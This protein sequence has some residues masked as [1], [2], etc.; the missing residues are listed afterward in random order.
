MTC[1]AAG[2]LRIAG[3]ATTTARC[4]AHHC[5][6]RTGIRASHRVPQRAGFHP[7]EADAA[8]MAEPETRL[9]PGRQKAVPANGLLHFVDPEASIRNSGFRGAGGRLVAG[10]NCSR[11]T[12]RLPAKSFEHPLE[13]L[14][15]I[16]SWSRKSLRSSRRRGRPARRTECRRSGISAKVFPLCVVVEPVMLARDFG[17]AGLGRPAARSR[18]R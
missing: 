14:F 7:A 17:D 1:C 11:T 18:W 8:P 6:D 15:F 4:P 2:W 5:R 9:P 16:G 13:R 12:G 3:E 10:K